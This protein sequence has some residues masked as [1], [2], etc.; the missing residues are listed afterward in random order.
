MVVNVQIRPTILEEDIECPFV[1]RKEFIQIFED[2]VQ[3]I[4]R[5]NYSVLVY[6]GVGGIGKTSLRKELPKIV[7]KHNESNR[8]IPI[9]WE[10]IDLIEETHR[11]PYKF[12]EVLGSRLHDKYGIKFHSF[13]IARAVHLKKINPRETLRGNEFFNDSIVVD[14]LNSGIKGEFDLVGLIP[15][16]LNIAKKSPDR[17]HQWL[18]QRRED[19]A[20]LPSMEASKI[21]RLLPVYWAYDL[22]DHLKKTSETTV[23]FIDSYEALWEK[24]M[25]RGSFN[26]R[27]EWIRV[28]VENLPEHVLWVICGREFL[29]WKEVN[30]AWENYLKQ[31]KIEKLPEEDAIDLLNQCGVVEKDIQKIIV[32]GSEGVPYY[33][34]LSIDTYRTV[35]KIRTPASQDFS[36]VRSEIFDRFIKYLDR[37]KATIMALSVPNFWDRDILKALI[38]EFNTGYPLNELSELLKFSFI[39]TEGQEIWRM[40]QLMRKSLLENQEIEE[41]VNV[42]HFMLKYYSGQLENID[43]KKIT[44]K[45]ENTLT[46]AF[47][48]AKNALDTEDLFKWFAKYSNPFYE[49]TLWR[50]LI[51]L[52]DEL[53]L[54]LMKISGSEHPD[55]AVVLNNMAGL[56]RDM[57]EYKKALSLYQRTLEIVEVLLSPEHPDVAVVLN[58]MA[59][60]YENMGEYEKAL[61]FCQRALEIVE[62]TLSPEHPDVAAILNNMAGIYKSIG[63]YDKAL[64]LY[65]RSLEIF[66]RVLGPEHIH[67][68]TTLNDIA[69]LYENM[70]EYEK[71]LPLF[72]RS[73]LTY[74]NILGSEHSYVATSLNNMAGLLKSKG[75]Y[76]KALSLYERALMIR[77]NILNPEHPDI[78]TTLNCIA[79]LHENMGEYE[80]ALTLYNRSLHIR[81][82]V[83]G[84]EHLSVAQTL[85]NMAGLYEKTGDFK[86]SLSFFQRALNIEY[87]V[88][89]P[90]HPNVASILNNLASLYFTVGDY[91]KALPLFQR[92]LEI[93]ESILGPEH[94]DVANTLDSLAVLYYSTG[95][96]EKALSLFQRALDIENKVLGPEHLDVANT[97]NNL[98]SLYCSTGDHEKALPLYQRA[99]D[100][101]EKFLGP[102]HPDVASSLNNLGG[103]YYRMGEYEKAL[104]LSQR[105]LEIL[106]KTLGSEHPTTI[107]IKSNF[108]ELLFKM[109]KDREE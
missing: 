75:E 15:N 3:N 8:S 2:S 105:S 46:E 34:E 33:L 4:G 60:L 63:K 104:S 100:I 88:L 84:S 73:L 27:D 54:Q 55:V 70:G 37:E 51:P 26:S 95:N 97:L 107:K 80:K 29:R 94:P 72:Q 87:K 61:S 5:Q 102:E 41:V 65:Q 103:L 19:I 50:S 21:E 106:E 17:C 81:E 74:E 11:R 101:E 93:R 31:R 25:N 52:H 22:I 57:G 1:D 42:H 49:A 69:G 32:E 45:N 78:A 44:S 20:K 96:N 36:S 66:E 92:S 58:N 7:E 13:E 68:A 40:H 23:V 12:L 99:L 56:Y 38:R 64:P 76:E 53:I 71:A 35:K 10:S 43:I 62:L 48:H 30:S 89:S 109:S 28:L 9:L 14:L 91:E 86:E 85:G 67:V 16:L 6:Y 108:S 90:E 83:L 39:S 47:F 24:E 98:A 77:E 18:F 59:R 82:K 79:A